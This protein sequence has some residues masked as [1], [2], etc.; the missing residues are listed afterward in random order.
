M[1][2]IRVVRVQYHRVLMQA[3]T[4]SK[5]TGVPLPVKPDIIR[6]AKTPQ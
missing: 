5:A 1:I 3:M 4:R 2:A 6:A